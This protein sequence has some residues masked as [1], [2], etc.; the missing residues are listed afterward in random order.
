MASAELLLVKNETFDHGLFPLRSKLTPQSFVTTFN[1]LIPITNQELK[2]TYDQFKEVLAKLFMTSLTHKDVKTYFIICKALFEED[3][4]FLSNVEANT[5]DTRAVGIFLFLQVLKHY[6]KRADATSGFTAL[7]PNSQFNEGLRGPGGS[8]LGSFSPINSPRAK[9]KTLS[10]NSNDM[11][12]ANNASMIKS[13]I[14][15]ICKLTGPPS[16]KEFPHLT[17]RDLNGL[18]LLLRTNYTNEIAKALKP[19]FSSAK[20]LDSQVLCSF[21][22]SHLGTSSPFEGAS[23]LESGSCILQNMNKSITVTEY[24]KYRN[25]EL[26][27][28]ACEE[29]YIFIDDVPDYLLISNC[30]NSV[31]FVSAVRLI[32]TIEKCEGCTITV[33]S[34]ILRVGN[35]IDSKIYSYSWHEPILYGDNK[36]IVMGPHN[37]NHATLVSRIKEARIPLSL[38]LTKNF[39]IP[40]VFNNN[41]TMTYELENKKDFQAL[42]LPQSFTC[43][44]SL[45]V[46]SFEKY[47]NLSQEDIMKN[48]AADDELVLPGLAPIHYKEALIQ[49]DSVF[50]KT[51]EMLITLKTSE[52]N[53][54]QLGTLVQGYFKEWLIQS[55]EAKKLA[56]IVRMID[57]EP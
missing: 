23:G 21:I 29:S 16:D 31:I 52:E 39:G 4:S 33:A 48:L 5:I 49:Q 28:V 42:I 36:S 19:L 8:G 43:L 11:S 10:G 2:F 3:T 35:T 30:C 13:S 41:S 57:Q 46:S 6:D 1:S 22:D 40:F 50:K 18:R 56:E 45:A 54:A 15:L 9:P 38:S 44:K 7:A 26:K 12:Y 34:G 53:K 25:K 20:T 24:G 14:K 17:E 47:V 55:G 27:I 37:A 32:A 51:R